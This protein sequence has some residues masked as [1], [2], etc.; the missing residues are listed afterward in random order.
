MLHL[1]SY[2]STMETMEGFKLEIFVSEA[3]A[4]TSWPPSV[5]T[6]GH[7]NGVGALCRPPECCPPECR[8]PE[9]RFYNISPNVARPNVARPNVAPG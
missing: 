1:P 2:N 3:A 8:P 4:M 5:S 7:S 9:C 6:L